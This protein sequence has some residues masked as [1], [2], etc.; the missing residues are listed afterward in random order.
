MRFRSSLQK[1]LELFSFH[2]HFISSKQENASHIAIESDKII[3][4]D[5]RRGQQDVK[6][7]ADMCKMDGYYEY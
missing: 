6:Q 5:V 4:K 2:K 7:G 1:G 3:T